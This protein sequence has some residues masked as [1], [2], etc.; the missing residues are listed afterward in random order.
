MKRPPRRLDAFLARAGLGSR[1]Q[2]RGLVRAGRVTLDG[3]VCRRA[4]AV[5]SGRAVACDGE[6]VELLE[7]EDVILHKPVGYACSHDWNEAPIID[8]LLHAGWAHLGLQPAGRLDRDT[9]GLLVLTCDGGLIHELT[10]PRRKVPKRYRIEYRGELPPDA[11]ERCAA[12]LWLR[13]DDPRPT[14]PAQLTLEGPGRATLV[15]WEGR[16]RQVRRTLGRLGVEV[17]ALHRD[18]IGGLDLP[19]DLEPGHARPLTA[20][21]RTRLLARDPP[22]P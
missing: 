22:P 15:L 12:G 19:S 18:R 13:P 2:V 14:R 5:V 9:S 11:V 20:D 8:E 10:S 21:Q 17:V 1:Q 7:V 3:E 6:P 4:D 16:N